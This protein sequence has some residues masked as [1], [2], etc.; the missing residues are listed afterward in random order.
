MSS[1]EF[2]LRLLYFLKLIETEEQLI[3]EK[4]FDVLLNIQK[5]KQQK[6]ALI[7]SEVKFLD[8][9]RSNMPKINTLVSEILRKAS[10]NHYNIDILYGAH[11]VF[12]IAVNKIA[13]E[14]SQSKVYGRLGNGMLRGYKHTEP[15][16]L[17]YKCN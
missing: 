11:S 2:E 1:T 17:N 13:K 6:L 16:M 14:K 3:I 7:L 4:K 10:I 5:E 15:I 8:K 9:K 12:A